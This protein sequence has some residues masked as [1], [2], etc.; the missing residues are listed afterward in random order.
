MSEP[1]AEAPFREFLRPFPRRHIRN[2][3]AAVLD[4]CAEL[5][6]KTRTDKENWLTRRLHARLIRIFPFRDGPLDIAVQ[7]EVPDI[8]NVDADRPAGQID[9]KVMCGRGAQVYFAIEAKRLRV[10]DHFGRMDSG[11]GDYC[12]NGMMRFITGQYAPSTSAG[13]MLGYVFDGDVPAARNDVFKA[14]EQRRDKLRLRDGT[15]LRQS[16]IL[17]TRAVGETVHEPDNR[18]LTLYHV[19]VAL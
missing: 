5:K 14:I 11:A 18:E 3:L 7:P 19:L 16:A 4:A 9:I 6:K 1:P 15:A 8:R 2:V 13:A 10:I 12:D 17:A